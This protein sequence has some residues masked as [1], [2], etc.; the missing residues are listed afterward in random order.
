MNIDKKTENPQSKDRLLVVLCLVGLLLCALPLASDRVYSFIFGRSR[1]GSTTPVIG[2]I[3]YAKNDIRHKNSD[4][5]TWDKAGEAQVIH[6]GD[7]VFTGDRSQS[8]VKLKDGGKVDIDQN[9]MVTFSKIDNMEV[10]NLAVGNFR[11]AVQ[12]KMKI[13]LNGE[14]TEI[15]GE[16]SEVQVVMTAHQKPQVRLLRGKANVKS[17]GRSQAL[18]QNT[19]TQVSNRE[20]RSPA[21]VPEKKAVL[22]PTPL[23]RPLYYVD[24]LY[25]YFENKNGALALRDIRRGF[26]KLDTEALWSIT[27]NNKGSFVYGQ[28]SNSSRF[29]LMGDSFKVNSLQSS[30]HFSNAYLGENYY[31]LSMD[32]RNWV[33]SS[34][35][36]KANPLNMP[37]PTLALGTEGKVFILDQAATLEVLPKGDMSFTHYVVEVSPSTAFRPSSTKVYWVTADDSLKL[38]L[39]EPQSLFIRARGVNSLNQITLSSLI[40]KVDVERPGLPFAPRLSKDEYKIYEDEWVKLTWNQASKST[41]MEVTDPQG[42][43]I[44]GEVLGHSK[45][46]K[47]LKVG[48]YHVKLSSKDEF[49][50]SSKSFARADIQVLARPKAPVAVAKVEPSKKKEPEKRVPAAVETSSMKMDDSGIPNYLNRRYSDSMLSLEGG[51]FTAYSQ[52]QV[53][54]GKQNPSAVSLG[55]R[56]MSWYGRSGFEGSFSTKVANIGSTSDGTLSP[57]D[58]EARYHYRF[59]LHWNPF[60]GLATSQM[61]VIFGYEYY[62]NPGGGLFAPQYDLLKT[63]ISLKFP[64]MS[65][66]D[67][68]GEFLYGYGLDASQ[69]YEVSGFVDYYLKTDWTLGV[70]YRA[71][72]FQAGSDASSPLGVPYREALGEAYSVLRWAY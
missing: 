20:V 37:P 47:H 22:K 13:A 45:E 62:R 23:A 46:F 29:S 40:T 72:I 52:E 9:S 25:D 30:G 4:S 65:R 63:G 34:F 6:I 19:L 15:D 69:K 28:L 51:G 36:V 43:K 14:M 57:I 59:P 21:Q 55:L 16:G 67:T 3:S 26:V 68:G 24:Q 8:Q 1:D 50:R 56:L 32:G 48:A 64:L 49:G 42:H 44:S 18:A 12:G 2:E 58:L 5:L 11:V 35:Y 66:W 60:S 70:G 27:G 41:V 33:M 17:G 53:D 10:P 31:R 71:Y 54:Q 38:S 7:S 61:S 39:T